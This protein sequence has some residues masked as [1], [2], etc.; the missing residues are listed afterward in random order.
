MADLTSHSYFSTLDITA[1]TNVLDMSNYFYRKPLDGAEAKFWNLVD[2]RQD[3]Q[4]DYVT[5]FEDA[6]IPVTITAINTADGDLTASGADTNLVVASGQGASRFIRVGQQFRDT[7]G[8]KREII[9]VTAVSTDSLTIQRGMGN[10]S[11]E[12]HDRA[13]VWELIGTLQFQGSE[14]GTPV[15]ANR[16]ARTNTMSIMDENIKLTRS[17]LRQ[18]MHAVSDNW[19][20]TN[21]RALRHYERQWE[22]HMVW[23]VG[24][25][26]TN[27]ATTEQG[28]M[29]GLVDLVDQYGDSTNM[30]DSDFGT[31]TYGKWDNIMKKFYDNGYGEDSDLVMLVPSIGKQAAAYIHSSALMGN[32]SS[33]TTRG[34]VADHLLSTFNHKIP[35]IPVA[36]IGNRFMIFPLEKVALRFVD[37][38]LVYDTILGQGGNDYAMRRWISEGTMEAHD[39]ADCFYMAEN[40]T[41]V[42]PED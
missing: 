22:K 41:F 39:L 3:A 29:M 26:R 35:I 32:Y 34:L 38:L 25:T 37:T 23:S 6:D 4:G 12:A 42:V 1:G 33:E 18:V 16:V 19:V 24:V 27:T 14:Q 21:E 31:F 28:S 20:W 15:G 30:I 13:A 10:S 2:K 40:V 5:W 8:D 11:A 17:Q 36:N 7:T 9:K